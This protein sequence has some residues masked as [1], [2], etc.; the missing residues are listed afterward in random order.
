MMYCVS[1]EKL[2]F[3][4]KRKLLK[5]FR[6]ICSTYCLFWFWKYKS[7]S[8][9]IFLILL[10]CFSIR[11]DTKKLNVKHFKKLNDYKIRPNCHILFA[12]GKVNSLIEWAN[13]H[14]M[15]TH[16]E[17]VTVKHC[18][19][20]ESLT[21]LCPRQGTYRVSHRFRLMKWDDYFWVDIDHFWIEQY[22]WRQ[23]GQHWKLARA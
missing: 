1:E 16:A 22:F 17:T 13:S 12:H 20:I 7:Q 14:S 3:S 5:I 2:L 23:L 21:M 15:R 19:V 9:V 4:L 11:K 8:Y 18:I 10:S 6:S